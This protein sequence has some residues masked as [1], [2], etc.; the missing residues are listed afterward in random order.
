MVPVKDLPCRESWNL[1]LGLRLFQVPRWV[2]AVVRFNVYVFLAIE[3]GSLV[4]LIFYSGWFFQIDYS[5]FDA[6]A[7][8]AQGL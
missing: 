5:F 7:F 6:V 1:G 8:L 3:L 4:V 2:L